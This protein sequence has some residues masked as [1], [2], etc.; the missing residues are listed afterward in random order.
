MPTLGKT[1]FELSRIFRLLNDHYYNG[2]LTAPI[3]AVQT[4]GKK[5]AYGWCTL[6]KVW[7]EDVPELEEDGEQEAAP[8]GRNYYEITLTAEYLN[9]ANEDIVETM[10]HEMA[11]LYNLQ[12]RIK[13][14]S[15][16]GTYHNEKFKATA[17]AHGLTVENHEKYGWAITALTDDAR[18][19]VQ[20][21]KIN[22]QAFKVARMAA[23]KGKE[24]AKTSSRKYVCACCG[25]TVRA[26]KEV[27]LICGDC[28]EPM[29]IES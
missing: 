2:E 23:K 21:L 26:T 18:A 7:R 27:N 28:H 13:D 3:I 12:H 8:V 16:G 1:I 4:Q 9:R 6:R 14:N 22:R 11:H 29:E 24:K 15:R 20:T 25:L 5:S 17:E 10:L 19:H